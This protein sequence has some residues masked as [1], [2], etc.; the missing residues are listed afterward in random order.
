MEKMEIVG[1]REV[2]FKDDNGRQVAGVSLYYLMDDD[3][4]NGKLAGKL[5]I[6]TQRR[7]VM[8]YFPGPGEEVVV[9][10]DR[11]GRPVEF[12]PAK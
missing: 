9:N 10:Y 4:T 2:N 12:A 3:R 7:Q 5:F 6:S 1:V 11:Y 8:T